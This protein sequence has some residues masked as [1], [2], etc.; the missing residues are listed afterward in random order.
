MKKIPNGEGETCR[1]T[2]ASTALSTTVSFDCLFA[3]GNGDMA[4][5]ET[6]SSL[7]LPVLGLHGLVSHS[8]SYPFR[9]MFTIVFRA[10]Q[11]C[12]SL[13]FRYFM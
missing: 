6:P 1:R 8:H 12:V 3:Q 13:Y 11:A 7:P 4:F 5:E 9:K 10:H 2:D